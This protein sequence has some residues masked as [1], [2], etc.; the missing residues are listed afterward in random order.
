MAG[1]A[2]T[3]NKEDDRLGGKSATER[4]KIAGLEKKKDLGKN[5]KIGMKVRKQ[6]VIRVGGSRA[7]KTSGE[8]PKKVI[9]RYIARKMGAIKACY[10][11]GLQG[12][13]GLQGKVRVKF[14]IMPN[15]QV[16][17]AKIQSSGLKSPKVEKCIVKNIKTWK[18][19]RAKGGGSTRVIYPFVFSRR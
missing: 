15:G 16:S 17:G 6:K 4:G 10:Q 8:L 19:P 1:L 13:P 12:N 7:S 14:L 18:F 5:V 2:A 11:R 9:K 3:A